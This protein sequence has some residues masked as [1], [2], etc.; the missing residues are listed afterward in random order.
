LVA[1]IAIAWWF[2]RARTALPAGEPGAV[3]SI[4]VLPFANV[5]ED[6][7]LDYLGDGIAESLISRLSPLE[8]LE[9]LARTTV[10]R[11]KGKDVDPLEVGRKLGVSAVVDGRVEEISG[12]LLIGAE[13]VN[14][15]SGA[16]IWGER[17]DRP[18]SDLFGIEEDVARR[19]SKSLAVRLGKREEERLAARP[20]DND[21]AYRL[22]LQGR[23]LWYERTMEGVQ[24]SIDLFRTAV[25]LDPNFA[26][27]WNGLGN[28]YTVGWAGYIGLPIEE[29]Y[30]RGETAVRRALA[31]DDDLPE[32]HTSLAFL[33]FERQWDWSG[34]ER[35]FRRALDLDPGSAYTHQAYGEYLY[36][37]GRFD[38]SLAQ[39]E[40]ARE[41]DPLSEI[42]ASVIGWSHLA[43]GDTERAIAQFQDVLDRTPGFIDAQ[44]GLTQAMFSAPRSDTERAAS[45]LDLMRAG[46][47]SRKDVDSLSEANDRGGL[48]DLLAALLVLE[49]DGRHQG[50]LSGPQFV[51]WTYG[52]L[53]E[54]AEAVKIFEKMY[55]ERSPAMSYAKTGPYFDPIRSEPRFKEILAE[56]K[57]PAT[58]GGR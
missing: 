43:R 33:L 46:G 49:K 11:F 1:A 47:L 15:S 6:P 29:A 53:G 54:K 27:A 35:E 22:Y 40:R 17:F 5:R 14:V 37:I 23:H 41:L 39:L 20:T 19:I 51:L 26:L 52:E 25:E 4:A 55:A 48:P 58:P 57:F 9:V 18:F 42:V 16:Q 12:R 44:D 21:E 28:A 13:L 8:G 7:N 31:L 38:E 32:A 45:L 30:R 3:R 2:V 34:A 24:K 50:W 56:M 36:C 10:F